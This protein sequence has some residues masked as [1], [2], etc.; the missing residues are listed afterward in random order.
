[1]KFT[2][3]LKNALFP[4]DYTCDICGAE[5]FNGNICEDCKKSVTLNNG[6]TCPVCGRKTG[7]AEI[8]IE[9]KHNAPEYTRAVSPLVYEE[10]VIVLISKFK[11]GGVY[12]KD[13]FA[14][15]INKKL[16]DFG[17]IDCMVS[18]P[19]TAKSKIKRGYDQVEKLAASLSE[20]SGIPYIRGAIEKVRQ[21]ALQKGLDRK[22]R[23]KN[24][25]G[26]FKAVKRKE[27]KDK[28]VLVLD[29]VLTTG[30]TADEISK[31]ILKA[32]AKRVYVATAASVEYKHIY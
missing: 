32:G 2:A 16:E 28:T 21:T 23:V 14:E 31:V 15:L 26:C 7:K 1:M 5:S 22:N 20:K 3:F 17:D 19:M 25:H 30:A 9:C 8:C 29:D 24:V 12:L 13:Y 10:G 27:L 18:V 4:L 6:I 11:N